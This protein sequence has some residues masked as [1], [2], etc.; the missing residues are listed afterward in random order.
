M[1]VNASDGEIANV[2]QREKPSQALGCQPSAVCDI[3]NCLRL[4]K[5]PASLESHGSFEAILGLCFY[6]YAGDFHNC[7]VSC[8]LDLPPKNSEQ[9]GP[10]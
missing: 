6:S 1:P 10:R 4:L 3:S 7:S 9:T 2:P 8:Y 5:D